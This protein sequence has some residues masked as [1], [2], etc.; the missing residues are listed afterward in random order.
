MK[1]D[2]VIPMVFNDDPLWEKDCAS[3]IGSDY[4]PSRYR[5]WGTEHQLIRCIKA[6]MPWINDII[7]I[8]ARESQK[9]EW[10][11]AEGVR[12]VYHEEF[13]P[14]KYLPCFSSC[15]IEMFLPYIQG[16]SEHFIYGNDDMFPLSPMKVTDFF[17][18]GIPCLHHVEKSFPVRKTIFHKK[19]RNQ[20]NMIGAKFG[21]QSDYIWIYNGHNL[22]PLLKSECLK[23]REM[24]DSEIVAGITPKRS[25]TSYSQYIYSL[26]LYF[27]KKFFDVKPKRR[28]VSLK[29]PI[30]V[31]RTVILSDNAGLVCVNDSE[32][33]ENFEETAVAV[34]DAIEKKIS[35]IH[36]NSG[37]A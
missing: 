6:C 31:V 7:I 8:L 9:K 28:F 3:H 5:S 30:D 32:M 24:F 35:F 36:S 14:K 19:C 17:I 11:D 23:V 1:I 20:Q 16:L 10:M 26:W 29:E 15:T 22:N 33:V 4:N 12:I 27:T 18:Y 34:R 21:W 25:V 13:I 2:Y 37:V